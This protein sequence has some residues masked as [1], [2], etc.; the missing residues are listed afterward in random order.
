MQLVTVEC[1]IDD[2]D[3]YIARCQLNNDFSQ[4]PHT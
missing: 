4:H 1:P 3:E 2:S